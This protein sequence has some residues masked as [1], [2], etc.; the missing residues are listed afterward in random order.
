MSLLVASTGAARTPP[1]RRG[2]IRPALGEHPQAAGAGDRAMSGG[3]PPSSRARGRARGRNDL[4]RAA[5]LYE[6]FTGHDVSQGQRVQVP[7]LPR[8]A[9]VIGE[10]DGVLYTTVRDGQTEK[11]IHKF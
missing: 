2:G 8:V 1:R 6:R 7:E 11:Y 3:V 5:N 10:C 4:E 9:A